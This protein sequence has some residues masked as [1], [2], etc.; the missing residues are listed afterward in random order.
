MHGLVVYTGED[1][2]IRMNSS[3]RATGAPVKISQTERLMDKEIKGLFVFLMLLC[4]M[5]GLMNWQW[6]DSHQH[7]FYL[8][9]E[10]DPLKA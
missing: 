2:K 4:I 5:A 1:T 6:E 8:L 3:E 7:H 10:D 9:S